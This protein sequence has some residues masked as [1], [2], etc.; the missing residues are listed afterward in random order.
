LRFSGVQRVVLKLAN[1]LKEA[2]MNIPEELLYTKEHEWIKIE[3]NL[4]TVGITDYAQNS[5]GDITFV[6]L[7]EVGSKVKQFEKFST[8]ES[9]KA[10]SDVYAPISGKIIKINEE[11]INAP[12]NINQSPYEKAW[13]AVIEIEDIKQKQNLL[14]SSNYRDY[15]EGLSE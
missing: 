4:A 9:V 6:E 12:E 2:R 3:G 10:A 13:F 14:S 15:I 1:S 8:V 11:L 5:L 7:P